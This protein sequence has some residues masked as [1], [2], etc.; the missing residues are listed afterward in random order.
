MK[1][2]GLFEPSIQEVCLLGI[3]SKKEKTLIQKDT[4][5]AMF[6]AAAFTIAKIWKQLP[7][8]LSIDGWIKEVYT[9]TDTHNG[10]VIIKKNQITQKIKIKKRKK[11]IRPCHS[12]QRT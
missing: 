5:T 12:Q 9:C 3:Y 11:R 2:Q 4:H 8:C 6:I 1:T 7:K 10:I